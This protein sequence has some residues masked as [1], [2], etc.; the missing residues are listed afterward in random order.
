MH[1][2]IKRKCTHCGKGYLTFIKEM[3]NFASI[4]KVYKHECNHCGKISLLNSKH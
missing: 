4:F 1:N 3:L 2:T